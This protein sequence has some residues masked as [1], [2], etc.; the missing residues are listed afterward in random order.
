MHMLARAAVFAFD[1][2]RFVVASHLWCQAGNIISPARQ[3]LSN[4]RVNAF[5][6][7]ISPP[8]CEISYG[9]SIGYDLIRLAALK[10]EFFQ[11]AHSAR[12]ASPGSVSTS[13]V[14]QAHF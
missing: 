7:N 3:N 2:M 6:H 14:A 4:D 1:K 11:S 5:T 10:A 9:L 8:F 13:S 12:P